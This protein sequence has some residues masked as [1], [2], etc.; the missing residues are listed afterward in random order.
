MPGVHKTIAVLRGDGI[1][2]EVTGA[3]IQIL[4]D[5]AKSFEHKFEFREL[6]FGGAAIDRFGVPLPARNVGRLPICGCNSA[7]RDRRPQVG[8]DAPG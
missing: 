3:A 7:R 5:C 2:P 4:E 6:A 8:R 1:G